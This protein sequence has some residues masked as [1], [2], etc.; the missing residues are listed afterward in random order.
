MD[1]ENSSNREKIL[2]R[3]VN[4]L[5]TDKQKQVNP[6]RLKQLK[7][8]CKNSDNHVSIVHEELFKQMNKN[9]SDIRLLC[10]LVFDELFTRS[11]VF[12][13]LTIEKFE[14]I[15]IL[16]TGVDS[17]KPL[18]LPKQTA[19]Q[20]RADSIQMFKRWIDTYVE[21]YPQLK[22]IHEALKRK[23][24]FS[25][26]T[27]LHDIDEI[28]RE[29][30]RERETALW[31]GRIL[32]VEKEV[33]EN[34]D[35]ID[36]CLQESNSAIQLWKEGDGPDLNDARSISVC[37]QYNVL[38]RRWIPLC[39][40][41][42]VTLTK[43]GRNT[44]HNLLRKCVELKRNLDSVFEEIVKLN[45]DFDRFNASRKV[46]SQTKRKNAE[47]EL[48]SDPTTLAANIKK[49]KTDFPA[50]PDFLS[51]NVMEKSSNS[52]ENNVSDKNDEKISDVQDDS[53]KKEIA[54]KSEESKAG[55]SKINRDNIPVIKLSELVTEY[56]VQST[57]DLECKWL[58]GERQESSTSSNI[59]SIKRVIPLSGKF[60]PVTR[61]CRHPLDNGSLCPRKDRVKCPFHGVIVDR[62][63]DGNV[64]EKSIFDP[65]SDKP[66]ISAAS[67]TEETGIM[68]VAKKKK[69]RKSTKLLSHAKEA[70]SSRLRL[71]KKIMNKSSMIRVAR[72]LDAQDKKRA[73]SRFT[74]QFNYSM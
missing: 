36:Q 57:M 69:E 73:N 20:L 24:N 1:E 6:V 9:N 26:N 32:Q 13:T 35:E 29:A 12:R 34:Q 38:Y 15:T 56:R 50:K 70:E 25:S 18:P 22:V 65:E 4:E 48:F 10:L 74:E 66:K 64:V 3:L 27:L 72:S 63:T 2:S 46:E 42:T 7:K 67:K 68:I 49:Y 16:C 19:K 51:G 71:T 30:E 33:E 53:N 8:E 52:I 39:K 55:G 14:E 47:E 23:V 28:R 54:V 11:H 62:D 37:D 31:R 17:L 21:G 44:H 58:C 41:W 5:V 61:S 59:T 45:I 40:T 43:A 60:E